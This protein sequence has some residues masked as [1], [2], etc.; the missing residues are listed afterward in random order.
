MDVWSAGVILYNML[1]GQLPFQVRHALVCILQLLRAQPQ[2]LSG[3]SARFWAL[4]C[5]CL[6]PAQGPPQSSRRSCSI[7]LAMLRLL[8]EGQGG[9]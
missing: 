4:S 5:C 2:M 6:R 1:T 8:L 9:P 3:L 7:V